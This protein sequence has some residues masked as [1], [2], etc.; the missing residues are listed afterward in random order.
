MWNY[1]NPLINKNVWEKGIKNKN[2]IMTA[3]DLKRMF[4]NTF[5]KMCYSSLQKAIMDIQ[6]NIYRQENWHFFFFAIKQLQDNGNRKYNLASMNL[7]NIF[8][9][10]V[11]VTAF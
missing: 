2:T 9:I 11:S 7:W 8:P 4:G 10:K 1:L 6:S 3:S 5:L